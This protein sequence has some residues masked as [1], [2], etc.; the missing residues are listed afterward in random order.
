MTDIYVKD[1]LYSKR[2]SFWVKRG[3][4]KSEV[5][6]SDDFILKKLEINFIN[7]FLPSEGVFLEAGCGNGINIFELYKMAPSRKFVGIDYSES[8]INDAKDV[9]IDNNIQSDVKFL[10]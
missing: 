9:A 10:L 2:K 1:D 7:K 4:L 3:E 5:S 8:M 6:G